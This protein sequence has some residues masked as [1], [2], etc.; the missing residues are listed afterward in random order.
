[1]KTFCNDKLRD[2]NFENKTL[3]LG[4]A[5]AHFHEL[6]EHRGSYIGFIDSYNEILFFSWANKNKWLLDYPIVM[7]NLHKQ[8]YA[9]KEECIGFIEKMYQ[10][11]DISSFEGFEDVPVEEFTLD[12][13]LAFKEEDQRALREEDELDDTITPVKP[14]TLQKKEPLPKAATPTTPKKSKSQALQTI[15]ERINPKLEPPKPNL[16]KIAEKLIKNK[17]TDDNSFFQI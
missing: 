3:K 5:K 6:S 12:E 14:S 7:G 11:Y 16:N 9:N 1:M 4:E 13:I 17:P 10:E 2:L 8:G 15:G